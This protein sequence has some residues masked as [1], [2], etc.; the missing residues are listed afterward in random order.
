[1]ADRG[2]VIDAFLT[3][4]GWA[5]A[6]R[7]PLA[8]AASFRRYERLA[9]GPRRA[10]LM[11]APLPHE[12]V[13]PFV[14]LARHLRHLDFNAPEIFAEAVDDGLLLIED[15]GDATFANLL[16]HGADPEPLFG[17]A[18]DVLADLHR[19]PTIEAVPAGLGKLDSAR[20]IDEACLLTDWFMPALFDRPTPTVVRTAFREA[21]QSTFDA[22][23]GGPPTLVLRD[24]FAENLMW[25]D[26][27]DAAA[28]CGLLDFQDALAGPAAYDLVSLLEDER[29]DMEDDLAGR[30]KARYRAA[31]PGL[32]PEAFETAYVILG[33]Q[34]HTKNI[35]IFT[36]LRVRDGKPAYLDHIP[37]M[38]R[39]LERGL[40]YAAL[41]SV[42]AWFD[43]HLPAETRVV[44]PCRTAAQ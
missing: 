24:F 29:R 11:D 3:F 14:R 43:R 28:A 22:M 35:G 5:A 21:W 12:D 44:P 6:G 32:D 15:F 42:A 2:P 19:R 13:A 18:V 26:G 4:H 41:S 17:A 31:A 38:W 23:D 27:R 34:R 36:R 39:W 30:L 20:L 25:L 10:V 9:D 33:A 40:G 16:D 7:R 8:G 1:M 37:R